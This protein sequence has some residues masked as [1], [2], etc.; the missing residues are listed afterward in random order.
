MHQP[1]T[2]ACFQYKCLLYY[3]LILLK[4]QETAESST[5]EV[6]LEK[7]DE[8]KDEENKDAKRSISSDSRENSTADIT[9]KKEVHKYFAI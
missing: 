3:K 8:T 5:V 1:D 7:E 9:P 2:F 4:F 6:K